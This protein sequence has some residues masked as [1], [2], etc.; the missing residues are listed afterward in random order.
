MLHGD[1]QKDSWKCILY[2]IIK[3]RKA[4]FMEH[5]Q[6]NAVFVHLPDVF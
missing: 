1:N 2:G 3:I 5:E 4:F 6:K